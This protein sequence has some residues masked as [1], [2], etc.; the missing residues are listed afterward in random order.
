MSR[1]MKWIGVGDSCKPEV[2]H[3]IPGSQ[4]LSLTWAMLVHIGTLERLTTLAGPPP[5]PPDQSDHRGKKRNLQQG[6]SGQAIFG[7]QFFGSQ[8]PPPSL[9]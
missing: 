9:M 7:T 2:Q 4:S 8:T 5:P 3:R 6:K 1:K